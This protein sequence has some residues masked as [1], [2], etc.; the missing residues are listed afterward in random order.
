MRTLSLICLMLF[1]FSANVHSQLTVSLAEGENYVSINRILVDDYWLEDE[2]RGPDV[3]LMFDQIVD[4]L[5]Q[6]RDQHGD[7]YYP[8]YDFNRISHWDI[9]ECYIVIVTDD[10]EV[11]WDGE[12]I[13]SDSDIPVNS[14]E[15]VLPYYPE[16]ELE[17]TAPDFYVLSPVIDRVVFAKDHTG[18]FMA[19]EFEFS[20]MD[21]WVSGHGYFVKFEFED[22]FAFNYPEE[23]EFEP[24]ERV[25]GTHWEHTGA[26][27]YNM[28]VLIAEIDGIEPGEGDQIA[29]FDRNDQLVG[30]GEVWDSMCGISIT[31]PQMG[32]EYQL[33]YWSGEH[34]I[35]LEIE[36]EYRHG[37]DCYEENSLAILSASVDYN[38]IKISNFAN[39]FNIFQAYPNPFNSTTTISFGLDKSAPARLTLYDLSGREA[40]TL[41]EGYKQAGCH[42]ATLTAGDLGSGLYFV[43]LD[44]GGFSQSRKVILVR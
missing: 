11:S 13:P 23:R 37:S 39:D 2:E 43:R 44:A 35:E 24:V 22:D 19:P 1:A 16:Y 21:P 38:S 14:E 28:S 42:T 3:I 10:V 7:F 41:F 9:T 33:R 12:L 15:I 36:S 18:N 31:L 6:I 8:E 40:M 30:V 27:C 29:A 26:T 17:A 5:F 25:Y 4:D 34:E 32:D 20:N